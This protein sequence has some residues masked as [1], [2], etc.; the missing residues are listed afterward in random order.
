MSSEL[1]D[2]EIA[3][4]SLMN[5]HAGMHPAT[6]LYESYP[7]WQAFF[8]KYGILDAVGIVQAMRNRQA[9]DPSIN[10]FKDE[11]QRL[12]GIQF[13][14]SDKVWDRGSEIYQDYLLIAYVV[15]ELGEIPDM[16]NGRSNYFHYDAD[17]NVRNDPIVY[18]LY[19]DENYCCRDRVNFAYAWGVWDLT[20]E[21]KSFS[22]SP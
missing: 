22:K 19:P 2:Y 1:F 17:L 16:L 20:L 18:P 11:I 7:E 15:I 5:E 3:A 12:D 8:E 14:Y 4:Y 10:L 6:P 9:E 13:D 21:P